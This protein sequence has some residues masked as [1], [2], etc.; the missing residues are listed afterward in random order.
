MRLLLIAGLLIFAYGCED[1]IGLGAS[2][3]VEMAD[4]RRAEGDSPD[5]RNTG[6]DGGD[7][8]EQ[9]IYDPAGGQPGRVYT[10]RWGL[11]Y[12]SCEVSGPAPLSVVPTEDGH[13]LV[14]IPTTEF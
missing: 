2:C 9:W 5:R 4:V 7:F 13:L 14:L 10:F 8:F 1:A 12:E 3:V 11:S 6:R